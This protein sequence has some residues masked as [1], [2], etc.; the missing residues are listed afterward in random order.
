MQIPGALLASLIGLFCAW[1]SPPEPQ[2]RVTAVLAEVDR[3][4]AKPLWPGFEPASI[5]LEIFDGGR[6][7]LVRHPRP[8]AEFVAVAGAAGLRVFEGRHA[9]MRANTAVEID[10]VLTATA[11][12]EASETTSRA[13]AALLLHEAFHVFQA[14]RHPK[15]GGNEAELFVY[16]FEDAEALAFRRIESRS[17]TLAI[18]AGNA[19]RRSAWASRAAAARRSRFSRLSAGSSGYERGTESKEGLARYIQA[20]A[21][22]ESGSPFPDTE[23]PPDKVRDRAY[24]SGSAMALLLDRLDPRWKEALERRDEPLDEILARAAAGTA[25]A[26]L[27]AQEEAEMRRRAASDVAAWSASRASLR[28]QFFAT[29]GWR[30][31]IESASPLLLQGF[32]PLNVERLS[33]DSIL[34]TRFVKLGNAEGAVE[35][36]DRRCL[37]E[38]AG[39]HPLFDGVRR[40]TVAGFP[41]EPPVDDSGD[42]V[43]IA[44]PGVTLA[45]RNATVSRS[46]NKITVAVG[47]AG[48]AAPRSGRSGGKGGDLGEFFWMTLPQKSRSGH[49]QSRSFSR[50]RVM[51]RRRPAVSRTS[52][53]L[54]SAR[55]RQRSRPNSPTS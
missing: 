34:H 28:E 4:A 31:V 13:L 18:E 50:S 33:A 54:R 51:S 32:D 55:R 39:K 20:R 1:V 6:T 47:P 46:G 44:V 37:T 53:S 17:L 35:I 9:T 49:W 42:T 52:S 36:L 11:S 25:P 10:G 24:A 43:R 30:L 38:A 8:P 12:L 19:R 22:G 16:P 40:A 14:R 3:E 45:F 26:S 15:W 41:G 2:A 23:F 7:W 48:S 29:P 5:P 21:A 27:P